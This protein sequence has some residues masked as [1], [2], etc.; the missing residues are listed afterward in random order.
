[1]AMTAV[2]I[3]NAAMAVVLT[4]RDVPEQVRDLLSQ[5][6]RERGQSLQA[7][8]LSVL[9]RQAAFSRN[10]Q[11]LAEIDQDLARGG[12]AGPDA[13]AAADLLEQARVER[14]DRRS[15]SAGRDVA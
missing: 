12:G 3:H 15:G 5:E 11:I 7:F 10:R 9:K 6:A 2:C 14:D 4:I 1:L 13:P 8:L